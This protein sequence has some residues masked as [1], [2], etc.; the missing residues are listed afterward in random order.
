MPRRQCLL[1]QAEHVLPLCVG[2]PQVPGIDPLTVLVH[3]QHS[4]DVSDI[5]PDRMT[6]R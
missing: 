3:D 4:A 5:L 6:P 2:H 1:R